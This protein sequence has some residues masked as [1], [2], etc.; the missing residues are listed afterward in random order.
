MKK[1]EFISELKNALG[2]VP[3]HIR[4]EILAD[5]SEHFTEAIAQGLTEEEVCRNLGQ[6]SIIA[7][8]V[9]EEYG[10]TRR[11]EK[12]T[13]FGGFEQVFDGIGQVF[14]NVGQIFSGK[15]GGGHDIEIDQSFTDIRT[16]DIKITESKLRFVPATD[17]RCRVTLYGRSRYNRFTAVNE[18][19]TLVVRD[20]SPVVR[21]EL[22]RFKSSLVTTVY[23]PLQFEGEIK[24]RNG[25]GNISVADTSGRLDI[26]SG[27]GTVTVENHRGV[28]VRV[29]T[30]AGKATVHLSG[31][32]E[33]ADISTGAG[34]AVF[35]A[36]ET[37]RLRLSSGAGSVEAQVTRLYG[38]TRVNSGA[39]SVKLTANELAGNID[40][41]SGAG[42]VKIS[43]PKE[44]NCRIDAK[45]PGVGSL[46]NELT[47]NPH[48]PYV[49]RASSGVGSIHLKAI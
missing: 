21:F 49:L 5:I 14:D 18:N 6:P 8:Q 15:S 47:G 7:A 10:E 40:A 23:V 39:G 41:N 25:V 31:R 43:L 26:K 46:H 1:Q 44:I 12:Q 29:H 37:G 20:N 42:S 45:K 36:E 3:P 35:T 33:D 16:I 17:G 32:T 27:T 48:S 30:G 11:S 19:G 28:K 9:L 24:A 2:Q 34:S 4:E 22:F 38:D 13:E